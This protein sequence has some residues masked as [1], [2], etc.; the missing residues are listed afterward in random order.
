MVEMVAYI[1][2]KLVVILEDDI[3]AEFEDRMKIKRRGRE[4][5]RQMKFWGRFSSKNLNIK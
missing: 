2:L 5:E 4:K 3:Y 1:D